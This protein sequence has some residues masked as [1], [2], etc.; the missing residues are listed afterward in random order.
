MDRELIKQELEE[1]VPR[2]IGQVR[3]VDG[4]IT[5][6]FSGT[7]ENTNGCWDYW[8]YSK[9]FDSLKEFQK[10]AEDFFKLN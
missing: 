1:Q 7:D 6:Y 5:A 4:K 10:Y 9:I 3:K 8:E 2:T